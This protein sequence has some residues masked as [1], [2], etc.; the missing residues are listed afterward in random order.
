MNRSINLLFVIC[1]FS[2]TATAQSN[3]P[4][5]LRDLVTPGTDTTTQPSLGETL[6]DFVSPG[7]DKKRNGS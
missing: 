7:R 1:L 4:E 3:V 6:E 2:S 5:T